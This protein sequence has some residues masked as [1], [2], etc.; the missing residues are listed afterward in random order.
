MD[1]FNQ[2]YDSI[3]NKDV[4]DID[5]K[6]MLGNVASLKNTDAKS[7]NVKSKD[8]NILAT[9]LIALL[10]NPPVTVETPSNLSPMDFRN[11]VKT[12]S[13]ATIESG[14]APSI[15]LELVNPNPNLSY[16]LYAGYRFIEEQDPAD[17]NTLYRLASMSKV[18][19]A[20]NMMQYV[21]KCKIFLDE[22]VAK[23]I[24]TFAHATVLKK[25]DYTSYAF[26][27]LTSTTGLREVVIDMSLS[28]V[29]NLNTLLGKRVGIKLAS[30]I[31]GV[32]VDGISK[33]VAADNVAQT[34]TVKLPRTS[35]VNGVHTVNG[36]LH[37][38]PAIPANWSPIDYIESSLTFPY[39][40]NRIYY[41]TEPLNKPLTVRH[42]LNHKCGIRYPGPFPRDEM[43]TLY[44]QVMAKL[45]REL[46]R[47]AVTPIA[48][49]DAVEWSNRLGKIPMLFQPDEDWAYGPQMAVV[50][51][52]LMQYERNHGHNM[53]LYQIQKKILF[54]PLGIKH[55]G[56]FIHDNDPDREYK[57][58]NLAHIY[59][60]LDTFANFPPTINPTVNT[61]IDSVVIFGLDN[62]VLPG[63]DAS[64]SD[65]LN[66]PDENNN[67]THPI[68]GSA[69]PR[70]LELGDAGL[71]I[72]TLDYIKIIDLIRNGGR[73]KNKQILKRNTVKQMIRNKIGDFSIYS[74]FTAGDQKWGYGF[75]VGDETNAAPVPLANV[76]AHWGGTFGS[77]WF[78]DLPPYNTSLAINSNIITNNLAS[79]ANIIAQNTHN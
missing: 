13:L 18:V 54:D 28:G 48:N 21:E 16:S 30:P 62:F 58:E 35:T 75:A 36:N 24:P 79:I 77:I 32:H 37:V 22:P 2:F 33:I 8:V 65:G 52:I 15:A 61:P 11:V 63:L 34:V 71:Y 17:K 69:R 42:L 40:T 59:T 41:S 46:I 51:A 57:I 12:L 7:N 9:N 67:P 73:Y 55:A 72:S 47:F 1:L 31:N 10:Q 68:Y 29:A 20:I 53:S 38:L 74:E 56:Y 60:M 78:S 4:K 23:Y 44:T 66:P 25:L 39:L 19:T 3:F 45:D 70:K 64:L 6:Q 50:G 27:E 26:T 5:F 14:F 76:S 49:M 43:D